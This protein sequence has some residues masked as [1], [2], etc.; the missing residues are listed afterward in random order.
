MTEHTFQWDTSGSDAQTFDL[1]S[2]H[3]GNKDAV[4]GS[5]YTVTGFVPGVP[6]KITATATNIR[7][8]ESIV[9]TPND[10][11][12][13]WFESNIDHLSFTKEHANTID[14]SI[15]KIMSNEI[16]IRVSHTLESYNDIENYTIRYDFFAE[17]DGHTQ[18]VSTYELSMT[19]TEQ[20]FPL[21]GLTP[22]TTYNLYYS[23]VVNPNNGSQDGWYYA[24]SHTWLSTFHTFTVKNV[25][26]DN[27]EIQQ[28]FATLS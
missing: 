17:A 12:T 11:D 3:D 16:S 26:F 27:P 10:G 2:I 20:V 13:V 1:V 22:S 23:I 19:E 15:D 5:T 21:M 14:L 18:S 7:T 6:Y 4:F 28:L 8:D 24:T 25:E 9:F